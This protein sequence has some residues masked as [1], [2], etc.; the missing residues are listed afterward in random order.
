MIFWVI[1]IWAKATFF[2]E[3]LF[4]GVARTWLGSRSVFFLGPKSLFLVQKSNFCHTTILVNGPFVALGV[5]VHFP[6]WERFSDFPFPSYSR[7]H[8]KN[9]VDPS[10]SLPPPHCGGRAP[11]ASN[12]PSPLSAQALRT[13]ALRARAG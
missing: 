7:F 2:F 3:Q 12:S 5:T 9:P 10:K 1:I 4:P 11:S 13:R 8:K 6:P